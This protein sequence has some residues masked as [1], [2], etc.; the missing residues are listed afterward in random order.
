MCVQRPCCCEVLVPVPVR[1]RAKH[2]YTPSGFLHPVLV[3]EPN[4]REAGE[5]NPNGTDNCKQLLNVPPPSVVGLYCAVVSSPS[6]KA[7]RTAGLL[8]PR[9]PFQ[10]DQTLKPLGRFREK[11]NDAAWSSP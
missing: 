11:K 1:V 3:V 6:M 7:S 8:S 9:C 10:S 2:G 5:R 4:G